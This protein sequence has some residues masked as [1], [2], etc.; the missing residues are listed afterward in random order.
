MNIDDA[1]TAI[2]L[3]A[4]LKHLDGQLK[5]LAEQGDPDRIY[6]VIGGAQFEFP[7]PGKDVISTCGAFAEDERDSVANQLAG[8]GVDLTVDG[9]GK[10][11]P[12]AKVAS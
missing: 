12:T 1:L 3:D 5:I 4:R 9:N 2:Q 11:S 7:T 6:I 8:L 10:M